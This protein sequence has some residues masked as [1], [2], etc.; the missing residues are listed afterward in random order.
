VI[1]RFR[2]A[3]A[4]ERQQMKWLV[5]ALALVLA[6]LAK[7]FLTNGFGDVV[8]AIDYAVIAAAVGVAIL[9]Y[10]LYDIDVVVNKTLLYGGLA[11]FITAV[12]VAIVV[13]LGAL[14]G[15]GS[16]PNL[17]LSIV[18]TALVAVAFAPAKQRMQHL[19]NRLVYG[20][21]ATPYE[22]LSGFADRMSKAYGGE[23]VLAEMARLA[24]QATAATATAVW[25]RLGPDRVPRGVWPS[26]GEPPAPRDGDPA[27]VPVRE[28][29]DVLGWIV[30]DRP[31]GAP[32]VPAE[33]RLLED[34]AAQAGLVLRNVRLIEELRSSRLRLVQAQDQERRRLERNIHDGAQQRLVALA[35][36]FNLARQVL[37][38]EAEAERRA[39]GGLT[40]QLQTAL[41]DLRN[42][43]RGIYPPLLADRGLVA[44]LEAQ[45]ARSPVP[46][47]VFAAGVA[48]YPQ[49]TEAAVYFCCLEALQNVA[50]YARASRV[51]VRIDADDHELRF[52]VSDDGIG[53]DV[54]TTPRGLGLTNM[55]DRLAAMDGALEVRSRMGEG[56][57]ITGRIAARALERTGEVAAR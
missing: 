19:A 12:Y 29:G 18:A 47:D 42:L 3:R 23:D 27:T 53:F 51:L 45:A 31:D 57:T 33:A 52:E 22:T 16:G 5:F 13:G 1:V 10:R 41:D 48:R 6:S 25:L 54:A 34:L 11:A 30:I 17:G 38:A 44:A 49:A 4:D 46:V 55:T 20:N 50:K 39:V 21:R 40:D 32:I 36:R 37:P 26:D 24:G 28:G 56:T 15:S 14:L 2:R 9:K 43:A 35:V 8:E 7:G